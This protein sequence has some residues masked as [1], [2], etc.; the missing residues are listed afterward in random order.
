M[1][2]ST[3]VVSTE[4]TNVTVTD[5]VVALHVIVATVASVSGESTI[6]AAAQVDGN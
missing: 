4:V 3:L 6:A 2:L 1:I 5:P